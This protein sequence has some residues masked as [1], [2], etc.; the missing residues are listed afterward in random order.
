MIRDVVRIDAEKCNG[1][2]VCAD[3][4][5]EGAIKMIDGKAVLVSEE[6]CDGLGA[7]LPSCPADAI[8][9]E[10]RDVQPYKERREDSLSIGLL[11]PSCSGTAPKSITRKNAADAS[12]P[13]PSR[14]EQWPVQLRLAPV[15]AAYFDGCDL[16]VAADCAA[17]A[18]GSFHE[19]FMKGR[20]VLI[21]CPKLDPPECWGKL[22]DIIAGNDVKSVTAGRMEVPCCSP[23]AKNAEEA[24]HRSGK[25]IPVSTLVLGIDGA[26]R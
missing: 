12:G 1:C 11:Q 25:R 5:A 13:C 6:C 24:V 3:T 2:G 10:K 16:L 15:S 18:C 21:G 4:C 17:F 20:K 26:R 22:C 8:T 7:C 23:I 14:L 19:D 9:I